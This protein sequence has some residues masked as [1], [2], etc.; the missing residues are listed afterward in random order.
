MVEVLYSC[1]CGLDVHKKTVVA[2]LLRAGVDSQRSQE[3]RTFGT[4]TDDLLALANWLTA[5]GC[6]HVAMESTGVYWKPVYNILEGQLEVMVVNAAHI[7]AVP[8]RKTDVKDAE[9]IADLLQY[10]LVRPSFIPDRPQRE[11]RDLTRTRTALIDERSAAVNRLQKVLEDANLKVAS[12]AT[13]IMGVSGRA[14]VEAILQGTTDPVTLA[15]LA[16]GRLRAKRTELERALAGRVSGHHRLLLTT[17]LAHVDF[18][19]EEIV[20]LSAEIAERLRPVA[21][22]MQRLDTIPGV[23]RQ[24]AEVLLAELGTELARFPSAAHLAS[25]AGMCPGNHESAGKRRS[26]RTRKGSKWLRRTL[27]EAACGAVRT[28]QAGR[29]ALAGHYRRLVAR[30]GRQKAIVAVGHRLLIIVYHVLRHDQ[31]YQEPTPT[32]LDQRRRRRARDRAID[33]LRH[34]GYDVTVTP[35]PAAA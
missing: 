33:H 3:V 11:L 1:R 35:M 28:K 6:T 18:L 24:T 12:V 29:T 17:H 16:K 5:A 10:G 13:D 26:G 2:C 34:L 19:D 20:R 27:I 32:D 31:S 25:W 9:W 23:D 21:D 30:R 4:M 14:M 7:K 15:E 22:Q 8:G